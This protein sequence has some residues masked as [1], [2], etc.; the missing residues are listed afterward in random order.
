MWQYDS[1][2]AGVATFYETIR[3]ERCFSDDTR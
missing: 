2:P 1:R 3:S